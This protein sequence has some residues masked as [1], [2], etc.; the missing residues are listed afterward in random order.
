M[1]AAPTLPAVAVARLPHGELGVDELDADPS[2]RLVNSYLRTDA[3]AP[4]WVASERRGT[5]RENA[6]G[7]AHRPRRPLVA[8]WR[9]AA[10][11]S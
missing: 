3:D 7:R 8:R 1:P 2:W 6:A 10:A 4:G 9:P 5:G 11:Y